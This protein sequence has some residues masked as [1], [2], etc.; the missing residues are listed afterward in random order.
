[1]SI[2]RQRGRASPLVSLNSVQGSTLDP[3]AFGDETVSASF[4]DQSRQNHRDTV[5][6]ATLGDFSV[7]FALLPGDFPVTLSGYAGG[8]RL[9]AARRHSDAAPAPFLDYRPSQRP[10]RE[11]VALPPIHA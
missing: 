6:V 3:D 4:S 2:Q 7:T 8:S 1:M 10:Q 11:N 5:T 9:L